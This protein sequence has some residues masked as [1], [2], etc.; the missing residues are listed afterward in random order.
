MSMKK[1]SIAHFQKNILQWYKLYGRHDLPWRPP[2][3]KL[4]RD[5]TLDP[6]RVLISEVMLQQTQVDRVREK[7]I[8]FIRKFP[9]LSCLAV[10]ST[11][12]LLAEWQGLGYNRRALNLRA[13]AQKIVKDHGG[14]VPQDLEVLKMLPGF[15]PYTAS[16]VMA[17]AFDKP[18]V[19]LDTNIRRIFIH[20]FFADQEKVH[21]N[22]LTGLIEK[23]IW[24]KSPR[25]WYGALM[26]YG[27]G[28]FKKISNP[29]AKSAH[30]VK[31]SK[32]EGSPRY[33]RAKILAQILEYGPHKNSQIKSFMKTDPHLLHYQ[34]NK[35]LQEIL[36]GLEADG[37]L[38]YTNNEWR[39]VN[40]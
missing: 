15:G 40:N 32:F 9:T 34:K 35:L 18:V 26:D 33:V 36:N 17:F 1:I 24:K 6:Y 14:V 5:G 38:Q 22:Q 28:A 13:C 12:D 16:A 2:S 31:Q 20:F 39:V 37:F 19:V 27:S 11:R 10:S 8:S 7:F 30:Y 3:L 23:S 4:R 29:N 21:D 25:I